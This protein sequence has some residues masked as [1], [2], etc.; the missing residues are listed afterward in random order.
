MKNHP[1]LGKTLQKQSKTLQ[2]YSKSLFRLRHRILRP[3][4]SLES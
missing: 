2:N 4:F 3:R 1:I